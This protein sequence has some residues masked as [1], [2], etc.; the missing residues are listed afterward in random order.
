MKS[1]KQHLKVGLFCLVWAGLGTWMLVASLVDE[2]GFNF[3]VRKGQPTKFV[4]PD[5]DPVF[6]WFWLI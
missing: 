5:T 3:R 6:F 2:G 1:A 4:S